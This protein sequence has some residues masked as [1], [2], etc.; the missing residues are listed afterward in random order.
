MD[1]AS[2]S[3]FDLLA[4]LTCGVCQGFGDFRNPRGALVEQPVGRRG[5]GR[6]RYM[7]MHH[8]NVAV[9]VRSA[10]AGCSV[11]AVIRDGLRYFHEAE[12]DEAAAAVSPAL[13]TGSMHAKSKM[14]AKQSDDDIQVA[15]RLAKCAKPRNPGENL[16]LGNIGKG[17][18]VLEHGSLDEL[19]LRGNTGQ[20]NIEVHVLNVNPLHFF[21]F[22]FKTSCRSISQD[23]KMFLM[24][25]S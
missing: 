8:P 18:I 20:R 1:N 25:D 2:D 13:A 23:D 17:R 21:L 3:S 15:T 16:D 12:F 6:Y 9:L 24:D 5:L 22:G 14:N 19:A 11:C 4:S 10:E 7:Y